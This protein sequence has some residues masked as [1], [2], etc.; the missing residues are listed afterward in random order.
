LLGC[1][2]DGCFKIG[3]EDGYACAVDLVS[4]VFDSWLCAQKLKEPFSNQF[5]KHKIA[6]EHCASLIDKS[7]YFWSTRVLNQQ[8]QF[9]VR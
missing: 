8:M 2:L 5:I 6:K 4:E 3:A 9:K 7:T 1:V